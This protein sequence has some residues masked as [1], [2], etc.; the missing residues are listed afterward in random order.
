MSKVNDF[1]TEAGVFFLATCDG[2]QPKARPLGAHLEIDGKILFGVGDFKNV[3]KQ[4]AANP[5]TEIVA[6]K[7]DGHWLRYTGKAVFEDDP[8]YAEMMLD[9]MPQLRDIYNET[10]GN[11]MMVFHLEDAT[12]VDI[13]VMGEG[14]DLL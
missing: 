5:K 10:T 14:E 1:L 8:K 13:P 12:A 6:A 11:K 2:D 3:Y 7:P 4:L 9:A